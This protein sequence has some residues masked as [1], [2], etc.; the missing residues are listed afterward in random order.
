MRRVSVNLI[1]WLMCATP[2]AAR[3]D[4]T[5]KCSWSEDPTRVVATCTRV[6]ESNTLR[7]IS[8]SKV[9]VLRARAWHMLKEFQYADADYS[10]AVA[11]VR[12]SAPYLSDEL[13][14][15]YLG[16]GDLRRLHG[17]YRDALDDYEEVLTYS[18]SHLRAL[19]LSGQMHEKVGD[20]RKALRQYR[21]LLEIAPNH[22][23]AQAAQK[24]LQTN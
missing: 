1:V 3:A 2:F 23:Q 10:R 22:A 21:R 11:L 14:E 9:H 8:L 18:P 20:S 13:A 5:S 16:R 15:M 4:E 6:I 24:K 17:K 19:F 7:E 12:E